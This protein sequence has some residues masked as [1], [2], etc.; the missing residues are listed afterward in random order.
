[1]R[2]LS[3]CLPEWCLIVQKVIIDCDPGH[4]DVIALIFAH[5]STYVQGVT[6]VSGNTNIEHTTANA[7]GVCALLDSDTQVFRG[8][9]HPLQREPVFGS[10]V[11]GA[12]GLGDVKLPEHNRTEETVGA[13]EFLLEGVDADTWI[14]AIGP[15]TN[16]ALALQRDPDWGKRFAGISLMGGSVKV[17]NVSAVA[18]FNIFHDPEAAAIVFASGI[19]IKMCG[20][21]LT[22]QFMTDQSTV[23]ALRG[24][25]KNNQKF[26]H[27]ARFAADCFENIHSAL[28][29]MGRKRRAALHDPCAVLALTHPELLQF[30]QRRVVVETKG[31]Y[32]TGMTVVDERYWATE[33]DLVE[34]GYQIDADAAM[35]VVLSTLGVKG[36]N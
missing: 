32:T 7:L 35:A 29:A 19:P 2:K 11:H 25:A 17:G 33:N 14:I 34:V 23:E 6:T 36:T 28:V 31:E 15:L 1:M 18:E 24:A 16:L 8:A 20:L 27:I 30:E 3:S 5:A 10:Q 22:T 13:V 4:D 9:A 12:T 26:S 21:N